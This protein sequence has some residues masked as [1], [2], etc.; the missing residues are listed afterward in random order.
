MPLPD[1]DVTIIVRN[2]DQLRLRFYRSLLRRVN[3]IATLFLS[4]SLSLS[5]LCSTRASNV[6]RIIFTQYSFLWLASSSF[7]RSFVP[8]APWP[9]APWLVL[10]LIDLRNRDISKLSTPTK[11]GRRKRRWL[12]VWFFPAAR[13]AKQASDQAS[14]RASTLAVA[15]RSKR[16]FSSGTSDHGASTVLAISRWQRAERYAF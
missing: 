16:P 15:K 10:P 3:P 14:E 2:I 8:V 9:V 13:F 11:S 12:A 6:A 7:V 5:A 1:R 4:L